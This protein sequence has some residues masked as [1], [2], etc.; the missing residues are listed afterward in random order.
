MTGPRQIDIFAQAL[1]SIR[2][3]R[4]VASAPACDRAPYDP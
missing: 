1:A 4:R 2:P 3:K